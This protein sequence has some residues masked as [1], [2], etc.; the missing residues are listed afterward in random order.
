MVRTIASVFLIILFYGTAA[1]DTTLVVPA[2]YALSFD[3]PFMFGKGDLIRIDCDSIYVLNNFTF[4]Y[5]RNLRK[6]LNNQDAGCSV[7]ID[8][9]KNSLKENI[10]LTERLMNN[11]RETSEL[12][13]QQYILTRN[14]LESAQK[15]LDISLEKLE[16]AGRLLDKSNRQVSRMKHRN[17]FEKVLFG[18]GGLGLGILIGIT[19]K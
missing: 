12:N 8:L 3:R 2:S 15:S 16:N 17:T 9:Y 1:Q 4:N 11:N 7:M 13:Q 6:A 18:I 14:N 19:I 5:F 10:A